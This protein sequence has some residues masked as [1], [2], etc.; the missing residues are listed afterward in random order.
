MKKTN[1]PSEI[2]R[3]VQRPA[4]YLGQEWGQVT[5]DPGAVDGRIALCF[6]DAYEIGM[7]HLGL[8]ILYARLNDHQRLWCERAFAPLPDMEKALRQ[9]DLPL[10]TLESG[11]PLARLDVL[12]FSLQH[13]LC[14]TNVLLM[15]D[16]AGIPLRNEDRRE[17][18]PLVVAGGPTACH[19]EAA[20]P[21]FDVIALGDGEELAAELTLTWV[22]ARRE[23]LS[24][25]QA[26]AELARHP[27]L[28]VPA[29][30]TVVEDPLSRRLVVAG[31]GGAALT[32]PLARG[33][34]IDDLDAYPFP[35]TGPV[36]VTEAVFDRAMV[37][38]SRGCTGGCRFCQAGMIYRPL[39]ERSPKKILQS[40]MEQLRH[41]GYDEASLTSLSTADYSQVGAL[42]EHAACCLGE[43]NVAL[44]VSSLRAHGLTRALSEALAAVRTSSL[45]LAPEAG[46]QRLRDVV[47]KNVTEEEIIRG[48]QAAITRSRQRIKLY[49]MLGLPTETEEDVRAIAEL[50]RTILRSVSGKGRKRPTLTVSASTFVPKPH[51]PLQWCRTIDLKE[52]R[53]K[54]ALLGR[55]LAPARIEA[56]CHDPRLSAV[57]AVIARGDRR[58]ADVIERAYKLGARFDGWDDLFNEAAWNQAFEEWP[59]DQA[60]YRQELPL[61]ARLPWDH[62]DVGPPRSF[63]AREYRRAYSARP[64]APCLRPD[65]QGELICHHC[66]IEC[67]LE[68]EQ[69]HRAE[70]AEQ[71]AGLPR[72][73]VRVA[74][75]AAVQ[76]WRYRLVFEKRDSLVFV[77]HLD[78]IR[79]LTRLF[80]RADVPLGYSRGFHPKPKMQFAAP[81][82]WGMG[83]LAEV[84]DLTLSEERPVEAT[85]KELQRVAPPG[86][87]PIAWRHLGTQ[88]PHA[89]KAVAAADL[90]LA[91]PELDIDLEEATAAVLAKETLMAE[92]KKGPINLRSSLLALAPC[93]DEPWMDQLQVRGA[94]IK[95]RVLLDNQGSVRPEDLTAW[96]GIDSPPADALRV[97]LF[98]QPIPTPLI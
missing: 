28:Y 19:P 16:L 62:L 89:A 2:L 96:L 53:E 50:A 11:T 41:A 77:G 32:E 20:A 56:R 29:L 8:R 74:P 97:Q 64:T 36:P 70:L 54:Q 83:G 65:E 87:V 49:F 76:Q 22:E 1:I 43:H 85:L 18:D 21:F 42:I 37:E 59:H 40:L 15:L 93:H 47:N 98:T 35:G 44:S 52:T 61:E 4:R 71:A 30:A 12:G 73:R 17:E 7:S 78:T 5:K 3:T 55:L 94:V 45:T 60:T 9:R 67:D 80:R 10:T 90:A 82:P 33:A 88:E 48:A 31:P 26:L 95:A 46:S 51:T 66:G 25:A 81:L 13:E 6:P 63:L 72:E 23:G 84:V 57:E 58:V 79:M 27:S 34:R 39:R 92:R 86:L 68:A 24:R 91:W 14:I 69:Q 75:P 38:I